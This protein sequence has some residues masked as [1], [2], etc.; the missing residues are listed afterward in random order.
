MPCRHGIFRVVHTHKYSKCNIL[1]SGGCFLL[2]S[3]I[4]RR[5]IY[6]SIK[7]LF[8]SE[9]LKEVVIYFMKDGTVQVIRENK[10]KMIEKEVKR[11]DSMKG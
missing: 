4:S 2:L 9:I 3:F 7:I 5:F 6:E 8:D 10:R 11:M 1:Y